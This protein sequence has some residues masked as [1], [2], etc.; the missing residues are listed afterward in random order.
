MGAARPFRQTGENGLEQDSNGRRHGRVTTSHMNRRQ[1]LVRTGLALPA[2]GFADLE[3]VGAAPEADA[4]SAG[5]T[6]ARS[7]GC[8]AA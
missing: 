6:C 1:L 3:E 7:S 5:T 2:A 4:A 8:R